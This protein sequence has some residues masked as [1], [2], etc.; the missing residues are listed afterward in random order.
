METI[1]NKIYVHFNTND[2]HIYEMKNSSPFLLK[3]VQ[4]AKRS[5]FRNAFLYPLY[6]F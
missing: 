6:S 1:N 2:V 3:K 5:H 4:I